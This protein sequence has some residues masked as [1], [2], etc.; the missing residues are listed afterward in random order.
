MRS[1]CL[2]NL[3][4]L[5]GCG[6]GAPNGAD[7]SADLSIGDLGGASDLAGEPDDLVAM[8]DAPRA[9]LSRPPD[10]AGRSCAPSGGCQNG[11]PCGSGCCEA[12]EWCDGEN[13][14]EECRCGSNPP[15]AAGDTCEAFGPMMINGCGAICCGMSQPCPQ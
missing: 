2:I 9:D 15:C 3:L 12:G 4:F 6:S 11:P 7:G 1:I 8:P 14:Q 10:I 13:G 5:I